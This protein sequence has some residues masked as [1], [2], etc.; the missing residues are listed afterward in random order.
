MHLVWYQK[1]TWLRDNVLLSIYN[2]NFSGDQKNR[3][4]FSFRTMQFLIDSIGKSNKVISDDIIDFCRPMSV[5]CKKNDIHVIEPID[6]PEFYGY[7]SDYDWV[8]FCSLFGKMIDLPEGFPM[9]CFDLKQELDRKVMNS[10]NCIDK[11]SF[12]KHL[13]YCKKL[14]NYPKQ[15]K[16]HNAIFDAIWNRDLFLFL[17]SI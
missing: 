15:T 13:E 12:Y 11:K 5:K 2:E 14:E 6:F 17:N 10:G 3:N 7:Y 1:D 4:P 8:L 9:Y 16:E